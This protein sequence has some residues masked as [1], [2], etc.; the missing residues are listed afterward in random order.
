MLFP[1]ATKS[2][3]ALNKFDSALEIHARGVLTFDAV[4]REPVERSKD[5][6]FGLSGCVEEASGCTTSKQSCRNSLSN[7]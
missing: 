4:R 3:H 6:S 1:N 7:C 2:V 5:K